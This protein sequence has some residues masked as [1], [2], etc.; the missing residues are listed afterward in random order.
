M[1]GKALKKDKKVGDT[2]PLNAIQICTATPGDSY[3]FFSVFVQMNRY[4]LQ[5][6]YY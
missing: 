2:E 3:L 6:S 5:E 1:G 4:E